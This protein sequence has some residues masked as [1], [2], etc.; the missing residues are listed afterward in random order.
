MK[1][2]SKAVLAG[3]LALAGT[4]A[5]TPASAFLGPACI[6]SVPN[7]FCTY[8][9]PCPVNDAVSN[10]RAALN[11][12]ELQNAR[13]LMEAVKDPQQAA[14]RAMRG[15]FSNAG[16]PGL[17][18]IGIDTTA[19]L[20]G[21]ISS[22]AGPLDLPPE[23]VGIS[24]DLTSAG[25][26]R[27]FVTSLA[28][29]EVTPQQFLELA[30]RNG[31]AMEALRSAGISPQQVSAL[32]SGGL[33]PDDALRF[34]TRLGMQSDVLRASGISERT[35]MDIA[36]GRMGLDEFK[37]LA[38]NSG[39][40]D[41]ALAQAGLDRQ[42]L[43]A[44]ARQPA[45]DELVGLLAQAGFDRSG[46]T[47][48]D[49]DPANL[50]ALS[51]GRLAPG[52]IDAIAARAGLD[53]AGLVVPGPDGA[54]TGSSTA[55]PGT[56]NDMISI[57]TA[58]I[59]GLDEAIAQTRGAAPPRPAER[60]GTAS[61]AMCEAG[62]TLIS[63]R[64]PPNGFGTDPA[65]IDM[66]ISGGNPDAFV[67]NQDA[68]LT[69]A[70]DT[71]GRS[72]ARGIVQRPLIERALSSVDSFETM[73]A[74]TQSLQDDLVVNDTIKSHLMTAR[75][76]TASLMTALLSVKAARK[77]ERD[78]LRP[79]PLV[80]GD[81][82]FLEAIEE[83]VVDPARERR[84]NAQRLESASRD[85][86]TLVRDANE[87]LL[88]KNLIN[89]AQRIEDSLP[90]I[91]ATIDRHESLKNALF[92]MEQYIVERLDVLY[93]D[94]GTRVWDRL[95][96]D[97]RARAGTY[98]D[99][100]KWTQGASTALGYSAAVATQAPRTDYGQRVRSGSDEDGNPVY[101]K[102]GTTPTRYAFVPSEG[103]FGEPMNTRAN[104]TVPGYDNDDRPS[105]SYADRVP[106]QYRLFGAFQVYL[107][108]VRRAEFSGEL[109]RGKSGGEMTSM[110]W[111]EMRV[112]APQCLAGPLPPTR[113]NIVRRPDLFDLS[114]DCGHLVWSYGDP[115]DYIDA[116][117]LGGADAA[118]W[119]SKISLDRI[120]SRTGGAAAVQARIDRIITEEMERDTR[121]QLQA[122][123]H[124][125]DS[126]KID[127]LLSTL[128]AARRD[129]SFSN[130]Y[131]MPAP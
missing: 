98:T 41:E 78:V 39:L 43:S 51:T 1:R 52:Q 76:E 30:D 102:I 75:A 58:S 31:A 63:A 16:I 20:N 66:A 47:N 118:L 53:P 113:D 82:R 17:D 90:R 54:I 25:I 114:P 23:L 99:P 21:D 116:S 13:T 69:A 56:T 36:S 10:A 28:N 86:S 130:R 27:N 94:E 100:N 34:A 22:L 108:L 119:L 37:R 9:V 85:Y 33:T 112:N 12:K 122:I 32:A 89:D 111:E 70:R 35:L 93:M 42:I 29:G 87:A 106:S 62:T 61:P 18:S 24:Q 71:Y 44:L 104:S 80:V 103:A 97:L 68:A 8:Q 19:V 57:P 109:R 6:P 67:E 83:S 40:T 74:Q 105:V 50:A 91:R 115:G 72:F 131:D 88:H 120:A 7:C 126:R 48:F 77:L 14:L 81:E 15:D 64:I 11:S 110:F 127:S 125:G 73:M 45:P 49:L 60:A 59:P 3:A 84:R 95:R 55:R 92:T 117:E 129:E 101:S 38:W 4:L 124:D 121:G 123:G 128:D 2:H 107:S 26:D 5:A 46:L 96:P 65:N 79:V